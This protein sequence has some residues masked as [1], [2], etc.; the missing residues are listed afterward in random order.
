MPHTV[1]VVTKCTETLVALFMYSNLILI[2]TVMVIHSEKHKCLLKDDH[3]LNIFVF[4]K[5]KMTTKAC[6]LW[7]WF[8]RKL[9]IHPRMRSNNTTEIPNEHQIKSQSKLI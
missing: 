9:S 5:L 6:V 3:K 2:Q 1:H 7:T 4:N 8:Q